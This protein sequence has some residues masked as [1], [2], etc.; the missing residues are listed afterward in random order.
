ME[1]FLIITLVA[2]LLILSGV[3]IAYGLAAL[4]IGVTFLVVGP[5][6]LP[7]LGSVA[8]G[9]VANFSL[10]AIPLFTLTAEVLSNA[11]ISDSAFDVFARRLRRLPGSLAIASNVLSTIFAAIV[12]S[13]AGNTAIMGLVAL[14]PMLKRGYDAGLACGTIAAGGGLGVLIP[15]STLFVLYGIVTE[16][17][18]GQL[19]IGGL[20]PGL[21]MSALMMVYI[22][23]I[24]VWRPHLVGRGPRSETLGG[25]ATADE[26]EVTHAS[27]APGVGSRLSST[28]RWLADLR[29]VGP[30]ILLLIFMT[31]GN[32]SGLATP[33]EIAGLG[34]AAAVFI[35]MFYGRFSVRGFAGALLGTARVTAMILLIVVMAAYLGRLFAFMGLSEQMIQSVRG[36]GW[37]PLGVV[38]L[39]NLIL[40][41]LGT[42]L[43]SA[44]I[45]LVVGPLM[46]SLIVSLGLDPIWWGVVFV[47]NMEIALITPPFGINIFVLKSIAPDIPLSTMDKGVAPFVA[48]QCLALVLCIVFPGI[49]TWLPNAMLSR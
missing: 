27:R 37:S 2:T 39:L 20:V 5:T 17:S 45:V 29:T 31:W 4:C 33:S 28:G 38:L 49:V 12:G 34:A 11:R 1:T 40:F 7:L 26:P 32:Y 14:R 15:P 10:I 21:L 30:V 47:I 6:R 42:L 24:A 36:L 43:D 18:V 23:I 3:P 41:I 22:I 19:L 44:A 25:A 48:V 35:V 13:S 9:E 8:Y 46:H 16:N